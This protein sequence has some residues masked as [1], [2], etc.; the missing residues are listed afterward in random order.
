[1]SVTSP[2]T[3]RFSKSCTD[4]FIS[5]FAIKSS[6]NIPPYLKGVATLPCEILRSA[7]TCTVISDKS[8]DSVA[9]RLRCG[10]RFSYHLT[11]YLSLSLVV[12]RW[13]TGQITYTWRTETVIAFVTF[14]HKLFLTSVS[15]ISSIFLQLF[16]VIES[17]TVVCCTQSLGVAIFKHGDFTR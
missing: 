6:L 14:L 16:W 12:K 17:Y 11:M 10:G 15:T 7:K 1:L 2:N 3:N 13:K 9:A 5:K 8:R 4:R